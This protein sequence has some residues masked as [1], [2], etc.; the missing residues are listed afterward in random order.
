MFARLKAAG[1]NLLRE[2]LT[3]TVTFLI[4]C[5]ERLS[6]LLVMV[7]GLSDSHFPLAALVSAAATTQ[8]I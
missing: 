7:Y 8:K 1:C 6:S 2:R 3:A 4:F 5:A